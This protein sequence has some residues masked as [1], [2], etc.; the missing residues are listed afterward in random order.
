M[1]GDKLF[2]ARVGESLWDCFLRPK[3]S[4]SLSRDTNSGLL[5]YLCQGTSTDCHKTQD[6][7]DLHHVPAKT[8]GRIVTQPNGQAQNKM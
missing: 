1:P 8:T 6:T 5:W 4:R 3:E 2:P 7:P